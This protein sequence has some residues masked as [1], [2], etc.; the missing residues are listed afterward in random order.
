MRLLFA[1]DS[2]IGSLTSKEISEMLTASAKEV[3]GDIEC[4]GIPV[5]DGGEGTVDALIEAV[6]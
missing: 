1:S 6:G 4:V 3:F 5:A 2:F